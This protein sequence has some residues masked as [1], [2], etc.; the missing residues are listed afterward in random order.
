LWRFVLHYPFPLDR[1]R[2]AGAARLLEGEHDFTSFAGAEGHTGEVGEGRVGI[3]DSGP[4]QDGPPGEPEHHEGA[5]LPLR[6]NASSMVRRI[7]QSRVLWRPR[8]SLLIYEVR[9]SGFLHHMVR[10]IVGTLIEVGRGKLAPQ[11][12]LRI[13]KARD[14]ARAGATAPARG[15]CLMRVEY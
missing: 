7:Y 5:L 10:N 4:R 3:G 8:T 9:G 1:E 14:R 15:L 12:M 2:M 11:D 6:E 13:L